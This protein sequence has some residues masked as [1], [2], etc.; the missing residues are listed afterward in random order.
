MMGP[1]MEVTR[2]EIFL[3]GVVLV[4]V[5]VLIVRTGQALRR[6]ARAWEKA[7]R[8]MH[9]HSH[10]LASTTTED[11]LAIRPRDEQLLMSAETALGWLVR[12]TGKRSDEVRA[13]Q[14][15]GWW[16]LESKQEAADQLK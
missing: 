2:L 16:I 3:C 1:T 9:S 8:I 10:L 7:A 11:G 15:G 4:A 13:V 6:R 12:L 14:V 5:A